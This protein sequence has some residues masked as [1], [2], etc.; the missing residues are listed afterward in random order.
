MKTNMIIMGIGLAIAT[1]AAGGTDPCVGTGVSAGA[2]VQRKCELE[3][4]G[5]IFHWGGTTYDRTI[6][7]WCC[8]ENGT[9]SGGT[10]GTDGGPWV[11]NGC[12]HH[13]DAGTSQ[14]VAVPACPT[15]TTPVGPGPE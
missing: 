7:Y 8:Y 4:C 1:A 11:E 13:D 2:V 9:Y 10:T 5:T 14:I 12:C 3:D 15:T 6:T